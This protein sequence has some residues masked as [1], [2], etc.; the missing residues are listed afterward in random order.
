ITT[1]FPYTTLFRSQ[2]AHLAEVT[3]LRTEFRELMQAAACPLIAALSTFVS[4]GGC[5][6]S[7]CEN[8]LFHA[9]PV[10]P[11]S[12]VRARVCGLHHSTQGRSRPNAGQG[13]L[14]AR[15]REFYRS[16]RPQNRSPCPL[17]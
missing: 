3:R 8:K 12:F 5:V 11:H 6:S 7:H 9:V 15:R 10:Q 16:F 1:L 14:L 17:R 13:S 4:V 2:E